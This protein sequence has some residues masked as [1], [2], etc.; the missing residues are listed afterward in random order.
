M[1]VP[2]SLS[3]WE[4]CFHFVMMAMCA[5]VPVVNLSS[6]QIHLVRRQKLVEV[7]NWSWNSSSSVPGSGNF[8]DS[9]RDSYAATAMERL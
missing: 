9:D 4:G 6:L 2:F 8:L 3:P 5:F 1:A 7:S